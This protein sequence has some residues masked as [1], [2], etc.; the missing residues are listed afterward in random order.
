MAH[1]II[2]SLPNHLP[3]YLLTYLQD[4]PSTLIDVR[5]VCK[6]W[7]ELCDRVLD[8]FWK[9]LSETLLKEYVYTPSK[10]HE[11]TLA[12]SQYSVMN[13]KR[14]YSVFEKLRM[15]I[16]DK[17]ILITE[18]QLSWLKKQNDQALEKLWKQ[19]LFDAINDSDKPPINAEINDVRSYLH[20]PC[21]AGILNQVDKLDFS[22]LELMLVPL[23]IEKFQELQELNL[24]NNELCTFPNL[25]F[26]KLL[27]LNL[28]FNQ[29]CYIPQLD[30][31]PNV[32]I[33]MSGNPLQE[34]RQRRLSGKFSCSVQ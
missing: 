17:L 19:R 11:I 1:D 26:P 22:S 10:R 2:S 3:T 23:E 21:H 16:P 30:Y 32:T 24:S 29:L 25:Q 5:R 31:S 9:R 20:D 8:Q 4:R 7:K 6:K 28:S 15:Q 33:T 27:E 12:P 14:A 34:V 18:D 13:F